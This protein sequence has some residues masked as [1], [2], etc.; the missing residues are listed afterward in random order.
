MIIRDL[1]ALSKGLPCNY[2]TFSFLFTIFI[3]KWLFGLLTPQYYNCSLPYKLL[4]ER[5]CKVKTSNFK[6][7]SKKQSPIFD[8]PTIV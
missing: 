1:V 4:A 6:D 8:F 2:T 3:S 5:D 7:S